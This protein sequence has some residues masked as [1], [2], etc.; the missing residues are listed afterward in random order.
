MWLY[1]VSDDLVFNC[2]AVKQTLHSCVSFASLKYTN[3]LC[4]LFIWGL[5]VDL[6]VIER[7]HASHWLRLSVSLS[8]SDFAQPAKHWEIGL[9]CYLYVRR[10]VPNA[11][12]YQQIATNSTHRGCCTFTR[13]TSLPLPLH[14]LLRASYSFARWM[15]LLKQSALTSSVRDK[16]LSLLNVV[17]WAL[18]TDKYKHRG[19]LCCI[20]SYLSTKEKNRAKNDIKWCVWLAEKQTA[21]EQRKWV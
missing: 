2:C 20:Y 1:S 5:S 19:L 16:G 17:G 18:C 8:V 6:E 21:C 10:V 9:G 7:L 15:P 11:M 14:N 3:C 4:W 12:H 13:T